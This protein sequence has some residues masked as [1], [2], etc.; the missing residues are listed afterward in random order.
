MCYTVTNKRQEDIVMYE[1]RVEVYRVKE[2]ENAMNALA[3][4]GWRVISVTSNE[5]LQWTV[6]DMVVVTF[7]RKTGNS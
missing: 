5:A 4:E 1:Y 2:A 3:R 7:E 6:K